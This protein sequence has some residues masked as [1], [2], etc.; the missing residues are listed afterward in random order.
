VAWLSKHYLKH[1]PR[2]FAAGPQKQFT[3]QQGSEETRSQLLK[4]VYAP[5]PNSP[6]Y[7]TMANHC[8]AW[9]DYYNPF[10]LTKVLEWQKLHPRQLLRIDKQKEQYGFAPEDFSDHFQVSLSHQSVQIEGYELGRG[11]SEAIYEALKRSTN[12][13]TDPEMFESPPSAEKL[14][15]LAHLENKQANVDVKKNLVMFRN[16]ILA[17]KF[18]IRTLNKKPELSVEELKHLHRLLLQDTDFGGFKNPLILKTGKPFGPVIGDYRAMVMQARGT[19]HTIYPY[20]REIPALV[21]RLIDQHNRE[22]ALPSVHPLLYCCHF[23]ATLLHI[24]PFHD[25]NGR[26][27]RLIFVGAM[28]RLGYI[29]PV[30]QDFN[31]D[32][33]LEALYLYDQKQPDAWLS[34]LCDA[35]SFYYD[36]A[37]M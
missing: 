20:P 36:E 9:K 3:Y 30:F 24:H 33:Y 8:E 22:V 17:Q 6:E 23:Y 28:A 4:A 37:E 18:A 21:S 31:R 12:S 10:D 11:D 34:M 13:F 5:T 1:F 27:A 29:P 16:N 32:D 7:D 35:V 2:T 15:K 26:I 19:Y 25:G 14:M